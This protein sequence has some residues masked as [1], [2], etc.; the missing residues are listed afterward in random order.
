MRVEAH[1]YLENT[2]DQ[3]RDAYGESKFAQ[4]ADLGM[5]AEGSAVQCLWLE[6]SRSRVVPRLAPFTV[7]STR[8]RGCTHNDLSV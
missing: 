1:R 2:Y 4:P 7:R 8:S 5:R 3:K 6:V